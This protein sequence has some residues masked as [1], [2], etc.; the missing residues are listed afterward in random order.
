MKTEISDIQTSSRMKWEHGEHSGTITFP[1]DY[2]EPTR[3]EWDGDPP[4]EGW[5]E[6]EVL[7]EAAAADAICA[8]ESQ[9]KADG[10]A[11][12]KPDGQAENKEL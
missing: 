12:G 8:A 3:I 5:E 4:D 9:R 1:E 6:I 7:V 2:H 11:D 10:K